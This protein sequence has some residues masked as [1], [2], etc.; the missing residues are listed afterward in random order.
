MAGVRLRGLDAGPV[1]PPFEGLAAE[2]VKRLAGLI[3]IGDGIAGR[4]DD[5]DGAAG[6]M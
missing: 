2:H 3:A 5:T 1:R 6:S 4:C